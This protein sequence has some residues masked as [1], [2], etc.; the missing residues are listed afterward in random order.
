M[1]NSDIFFSTGLSSVTDSEKA[2]IIMYVHIHVHAKTN[3]F[4]DTYD[5]KLYI[6]EFR[7]AL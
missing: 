7:T 4:Y 5:Y 1:N 2:E 6:E 3:F